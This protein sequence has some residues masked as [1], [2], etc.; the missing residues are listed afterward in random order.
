MGDWLYSAQ[1]LLGGAVHKLPQHVLFGVDMG[2]EG[3]ALHVQL[4]GDVAH[5]GGVGTDAEG[6]GRAEVVGY[7]A[8]LQLADGGDTYEEEGE[9]A[10]DPAAQFVGDVCLDY[11]IDGGV[12]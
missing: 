3:A 5:G 12:D 4:A 11:R 6:Y 1:E 7:E 10:V 2:I 9:D 8:G